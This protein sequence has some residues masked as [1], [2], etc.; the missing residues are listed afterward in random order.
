MTIKVLA[1]DVAGTTGW[2]VRRE[3]DLRWGEKEFT[4]PRKGR[5]TMPDSHPGER[6]MEMHIWLRQMI[7]EYNPTHIAYEVPG[8][9]SSRFSAMLLMGMRGVVFSIAAFYKFDVMEIYPNTL[10]KW[11]TG[12]G[13]AT[14]EDM[15]DHLGRQ[16][17]VKGRLMVPGMVPTDNEVD[18]AWLAEWAWQKIRLNT[19]TREAS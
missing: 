5:K 14:K 18:A 12:S 3:K 4:P 2:A 13:K 9:G 19:R 8:G 17:L 16:V 15:R 6:F 10:K 1:L 11:A 7:R